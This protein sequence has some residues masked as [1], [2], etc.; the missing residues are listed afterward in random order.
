MNSDKG[1][2]RL[3]HNL[4]EEADFHIACPSVSEIENRAWSRTLGMKEKD[5]MPWSEL[6]AAIRQDDKLMNR[7]R[8]ALRITR[9]PRMAGNYAA[10]LDK[11]AEEMP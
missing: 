8:E 9:R 7:L 6:G 10:Q 5:A 3:K 2:P 11:L 4:R 1:S